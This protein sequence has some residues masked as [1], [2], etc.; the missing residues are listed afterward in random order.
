MSGAAARYSSPME[1]RALEEPRF[2]RFSELFAEF[3]PPDADSVYAELG[4]TPAEAARLPREVGEL[5]QVEVDGL[6]VGYAWIEL[7]ERMLHVHALLLEPEYRGVGLGARV[8]AELEREF[9]DRA[10]DVELGALPDNEQALALYEKAGFEQVGERLGFLI[11]RKRRRA[12]IGDG[13][14]EDVGRR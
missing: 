6:V 8:L 3:M 4:L 14:G 13:C 9:D 12:G 10:D 1:L 2:P 5:R 7:R 11:M